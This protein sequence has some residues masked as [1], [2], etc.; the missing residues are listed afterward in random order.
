MV[1]LPLVKG[2]ARAAALG[3]GRLGCCWHPGPQPVWGV[4]RGTVTF[5]DFVFTIVL[6]GAQCCHLSMAPS[7][8]LC[9]FLVHCHLEPLFLSPFWRQTPGLCTVTPHMEE[10]VLVL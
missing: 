1:T 6:S 4:T 10:H 5:C 3:P 9:P 7:P 2:Q 8:D